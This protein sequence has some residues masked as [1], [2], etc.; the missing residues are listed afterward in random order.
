MKV[1]LQAGHFPSGGGAPGEAQWCM[2]IANLLAERLRARGVEVN[3]IGDFYGTAAPAVCA[4]RHDLF[5]SLHYDAPKQR[6]GVWDASGCFCDYSPTDP[7]RAQAE[8][9]RAIWE[10]HYSAATGIGVDAYRGEGNPNTDRYYAWSALHP[11]TVAVI[12]EHGCGSP[13]AKD[14]Y[15]PGGDATFLHAHKPAVANADAAAILAYL[16]LGATDVTPEQ[17]TILDAAARQTAAGNT[18]A[19]GGDLDWWIGTWHENDAQ[20]KDLKRLLSLSQGETAAANA[21]L[22]EAKAALEA[23]PPADAGNVAV[24]SAAITLTGG[25]VQV[26]TA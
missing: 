21:A 1:L 20:N 13:V 5:V 4:S 24:L 14:G 19:S 23:R 17:Q 26:L 15:P 6:N 25:K 8:Q 11:Q 2:D 7:K 3:V 10:P 18:I 9:F 12:L 16:G 22:A